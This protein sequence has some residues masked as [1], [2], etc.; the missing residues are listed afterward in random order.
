VNI[1]FSICFGCLFT[2]LNRK[3]DAA[4][5]HPTLRGTGVT[6][7]TLKETLDAFEGNKDLIYF[8][9]VKDIS[10]VSP[11]CKVFTQPLFSVFYYS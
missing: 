7:P 3:L 9:D 5:H 11:L 4:F 2:F 1:F 10:A 6:I 8:F